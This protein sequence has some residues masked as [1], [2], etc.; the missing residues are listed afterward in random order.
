TPPRPGLRSLRDGDPIPDPLEGFLADAADVEQVVDFLERPVLLAILDDAVGVR[1]ADPWER[2]ELLRRGGVDVDLLGGGLRRG[3][4][5]GTP[6]TRAGEEALAPATTL[7]G[8][9]C[10]E[11]CGPAAR[12]RRP[13]R[14]ARMATGCGRGRR[15]PSAPGRPRGDS[16]G[17][18][19]RCQ[20]AGR[21]I[22]G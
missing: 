4:G 21:P 15:A 2:R 7:G 5:R 9:A 18:M 10:G 14:E 19:E 20:A 12:C 13:R 3:R 1:L 6:G 17:T 22:R 11:T 16:P 8:A